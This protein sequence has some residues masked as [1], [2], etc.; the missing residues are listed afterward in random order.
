MV[1]RIFVSYSRVD[2]PFVDDFIPLLRQKYDVWFD[3]EVKGGQDWWYEILHQI[4]QSD[5]FIYLLSN[6][7]VDSDFCMGEYEEAKRIQKQVLPVVIRART[8]IPEDLQRLQYVDFSTGVKSSDSWKNL[9]DAIDYLSS[10][11]PKSAILHKSEST[12]LPDESRVQF[13]QAIH[14]STENTR[15]TLYAEVT[16]V[17]Y[18]ALWNRNV[19]ELRR[20]LNLGITENVRR[21]FGEYALMYTRIAEKLAAEKLLQERPLRNEQVLELV[22]KIAKQ[23]GIQAKATNN[24]LGYD[25]VT[26]RPLGSNG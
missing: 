17:L 21:H 4:N 24:I 23:I 20:D 7:S 9:N 22:L 18:W 5:I 2:R 3:K 19:V 12:P 13:V 10:R 8:E 15:A 25:L 14:D 16:N 6:E 26:K 11:I 1:L